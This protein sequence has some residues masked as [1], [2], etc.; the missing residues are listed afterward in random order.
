MSHPVE[1]QSFDVDE[2]VSGEAVSCVRGW[3]EEKEGRMRMVPD[4]KKVFVQR[5]SMR[6]GRSSLISAAVLAVDFRPC[7][8]APGKNFVWALIGRAGRERLGFPGVL[9]PTNHP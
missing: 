3:E 8:G 5:P 4:G 7:F 6:A 2:A 9:G 1:W